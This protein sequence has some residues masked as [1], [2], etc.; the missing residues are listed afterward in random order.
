MKQ[1]VPSYCITG[2]DYLATRQSLPAIAA[3]LVRVVG[4]LRELG[5][6]PKRASVTIEVGDEPILNI[7]LEGLCPANDPDRI[8]TL[9]ALHTL[10]E[11]ASHANLI[12]ISGESPALFTPRILAVD[13]AGIPYAGV[14]GVGIGEIHPVSHPR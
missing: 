10:F 9:S 3:H 12:D 14:I 1:V 8:D 5:E 13:P 2:S 7:R 11:L 6:F 4:E